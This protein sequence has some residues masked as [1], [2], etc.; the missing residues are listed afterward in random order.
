MEKEICFSLLGNKIKFIEDKDVW[1]TPSI[2]LIAFILFG[3][4]EIF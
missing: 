1:V 2:P 3:Y 4:M